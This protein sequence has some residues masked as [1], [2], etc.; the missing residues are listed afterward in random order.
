MKNI[1][2]KNEEYLP[3]KTTEEPEEGQ[4]TNQQQSH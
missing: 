3:E 2:L 1:Y 4:P